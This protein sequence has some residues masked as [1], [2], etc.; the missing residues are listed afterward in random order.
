[1]GKLVLKKNG[2]LTPAGKALVDARKRSL[3]K[4]DDEAHIFIGKS[5]VCQ[6]GEEKAEKESRE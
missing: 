1:M 6:C 4:C 2:K 3:L 5:K